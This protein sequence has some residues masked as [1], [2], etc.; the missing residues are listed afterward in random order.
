MIARVADRLSTRYVNLS[1]RTVRSVAGFAVIAMLTGCGNLS[2]YAQSIQGQ[3]EIFAKRRP[4]DTV[5]ADPG[6]ALATRQRLEQVQALR[7]FATQELRL[8]NNAS[9]QSY[10]DL[11][12]E[13]VVWNVFATPELSLQPLSWCFLVVG[14]LDYRGYF[15]KVRAEEFARELRAS[16]HDVFVG[17][18]AAYSTLGWFDDPVLNTMLQWDDARLAKVVF[19]EL[20][21]QQLYVADDTEFN[22][23]FATTVAKAGL[24]LWIADSP[25][26]GSMASAATSEARDHQFVELITRTRERLQALYDGPL[27]IEEKRSEKQRLFDELRSNYRQL[28]KLW[29]DYD[30][31]DD[32][33]SVDLNN[34]KIQ[35][36]ATYHGDEAAF[37]KLLALVANDFE[38][39]YLQAARVAKLNHAPRHACLDALVNLPT[40]ADSLPPICGG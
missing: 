2:Y 35:S 10:A 40:G 4:I 18:V 34:A 29:D 3:L 32:W 33:M 13:Y 8:P 30:G 9:Y 7:Q 25:E 24:Q 5:L 23:A 19:H 28:R 14:C 31:Y 6:T 17:G 36:I 21:H 39:F 22:E 20:A 15:A 26:R 16:A 11:G 1:D 37:T 27:A 12:R 38:S